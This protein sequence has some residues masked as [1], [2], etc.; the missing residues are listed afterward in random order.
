MSRVLP[1]KV[2]KINK[3][4]SNIENKK[5]TVRHLYNEQTFCDEG[6]NKVVMA[7]I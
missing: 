2:H 6:V 7:H 3:T 5:R 1:P 4:L